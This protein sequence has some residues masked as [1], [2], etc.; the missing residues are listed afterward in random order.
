M[1]DKQLTVSDL[2][3]LIQDREE[4]RAELQLLALRAYEQWRE[5]EAKIRELEERLDHCYGEISVARAGTLAV[6]LRHS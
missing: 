4:T 6:M 1:C 5:L 3:A 2:T